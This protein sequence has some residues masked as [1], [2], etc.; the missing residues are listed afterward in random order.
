[1]ASLNLSSTS[2]VIFNNL[3]KR[4]ILVAMPYDNLDDLVDRKADE[5]LAFAW[6]PILKILTAA[7]LIFSSNKVTG[8]R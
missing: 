8:I 4:C 5:L 6:W 7:K 2:L 3:E 1:M